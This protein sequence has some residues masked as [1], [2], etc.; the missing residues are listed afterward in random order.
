MS[1]SR[2]AL[3]TAIVA[4]TGALSAPV[5]LAQKAPAKPAT[6]KTIK[7]T[8]KSAKQAKPK[9]TSKA[10]AKAKTK[11]KPKRAPASTRAS[12]EPIK[13]TKSKLKAS[14]CAGLA[15]RQ[16]TA[17]KECGW[18]KPKKKVSSNGRK[19]TPYCRKVAGIA[20]KKKAQ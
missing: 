20:R 4:L 19:L 18:I 1:F 10:K 3:L 12:A 13:K 8:E 15:Q 14:A 7:K 11:P 9:T 16:C 17:K 6:K 5:V 2:I